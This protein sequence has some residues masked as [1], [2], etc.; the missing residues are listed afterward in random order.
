MPR[1]YISLNLLRLH[2]YFD[3][4]NLKK[5]I[6]IKLQTSKNISISFSFRNENGISG[7]YQGRN[8]SIIKT[9]SYIHVLLNLEQIF[10]IDTFCLIKSIFYFSA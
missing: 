7:P 4:D 8:R 6:N 9:L 2:I 5:S 1:D 10:L 3:I